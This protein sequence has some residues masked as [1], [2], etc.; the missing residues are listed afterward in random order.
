[1]QAQ[2][3]RPNPRFLRV[4]RYRLDTEEP[5]PHRINRFILFHG[6]RHPDEVGSEAVR[7][8]PTDLAVR[9]EV[10]ASIQNQALRA[11]LF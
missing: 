6:K 4:N 11:L 3:T 5:Y 10:A 2:T 7:S 9:G 1:M 8:F